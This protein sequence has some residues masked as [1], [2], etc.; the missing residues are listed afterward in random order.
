[1]PRHDFICAGFA[2][3]L[4]A[5]VRFQDQR[6]RLARDTFSGDF[7]RRTPVG[8]GKVTLRANRQGGEKQTCSEW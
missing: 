2:E 5:A 4:V 3:H 1:M 6:R 7:D 8:P